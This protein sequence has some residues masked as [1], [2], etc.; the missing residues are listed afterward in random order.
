M[1]SGIRTFSLGQYVEA[2]LQLVEYERDEDDVINVAVPV[3]P[4]NFAQGVS[5]E[6][7]RANLRDAIEGNVML[8]LQLGLPIAPISGIAID[9]AALCDN[10][11][12]SFNHIPNPI[13]SPMA[14]TFFDKRRPPWHA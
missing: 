2:A 10:R 5:F 6:D 7:A 12:P 8:A 3:L 14:H 11:Q 9:N 1:V 4:G 13:R